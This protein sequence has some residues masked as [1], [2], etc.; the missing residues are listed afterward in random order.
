MH[1]VWLRSPTCSFNCSFHVQSIQSCKILSKT[2]VVD[3]RPMN[4]N[5]DQMTV[6]LL[7][8]N[9]TFIFR[10]DC[11]FLN[12][13]CTIWANTLIIMCGFCKTAHY[14]KACST[15]QVCVSLVLPG[16][17]RKVGVRVRRR[18]CRG[19][20]WQNFIVRQLWSYCKELWATVAVYWIYLA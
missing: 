20:M 10:F 4:N 19:P 14:T 6:Y 15:V 18:P 1:N 3:L 2:F 9:C 7:T 16:P 8:A 13:N 17:D 12:F 5:S 11:T